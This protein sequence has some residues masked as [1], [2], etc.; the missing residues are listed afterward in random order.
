[1]DHK[2]TLEGTVGVIFHHG[3]AL[4][5]TLVHQVFILLLINISVLNY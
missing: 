2:C 3:A 4:V 5:C 1:M